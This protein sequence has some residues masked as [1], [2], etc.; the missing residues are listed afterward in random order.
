MPCSTTKFQ[1]CVDSIMSAPCWFPSISQDILGKW[2]RRGPIH[3]TSLSYHFLREKDRNSQWRSVWLRMDMKHL[4][5]QAIHGFTKIL[6]MYSSLKT[7][8]SHTKTTWCT[9]RVYRFKAQYTN[10][11]FQYT[12][13]KCSIFKPADIWML[14]LRRLTCKQYCVTVLS[15]SG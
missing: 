7:K 8:C 3:F 14:A 12:I 1:N 15:N 10:C 5:M 4:V 6:L 11:W 13:F 9:Y 2:M